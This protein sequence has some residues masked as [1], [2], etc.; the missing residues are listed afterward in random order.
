MAVS[1]PGQE[2]LERSA[3]QMDAKNGD[4]VLRME[5]GFPGKRENGQFQES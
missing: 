4:I 5:I 2:V 1:C 3:C